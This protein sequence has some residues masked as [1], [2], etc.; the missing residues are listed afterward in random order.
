MTEIRGKRVL[1]T[2]GAGFIGTHM[3]KRLAA[4]NEVAVLDVA[5][6]GS[7]GY[8]PLARTGRIRTIQADVRDAEAVERAV[9][10]AQIVLHFASLIGVRH[11][12]SHAR[13]TMDTVLLGT[14]NVLE[15]AAR[16]RADIERVVYLSTSEVY[17][18][19]LAAGEASP[20]SM[21]CGNDPRVSYAS[22][23][24]A[25]E[26]M[27]WAYHRDFG[28]PTVIIRPFNVYGPYRTVS[29]A[30][31]I[32]AVKALSGSPITV[33]GDG[34]QL[35]SWCYVDDFCD[36]LVEALARPAA[37]G[38][39][40]NVG[41]PDASVT[42]HALAERIVEL[43]ASASCIRFLPHSFSDIGVRAPQ[44][45]HARQWL[46]FNPAHDLVSGLRRTIA[47]YREHLA[48]FHEW[49]E[50]APAARP[51]PAHEPAPLPRA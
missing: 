25:G 5:F 29:H 35:R 46:G 12:I 34:T 30:V 45:D 38:Q 15:A 40:F 4:E 22:A 13:L 20:A 10:G 43:S 16:H 36:A 33:H 17:G 9:A 39:H 47:W 14:R 3:A 24:L 18:D 1:I 21:G 51:R 31:G 49:Q 6:G 37:V 32:F 42:I 23:K 41:N 50:P 28:L 7:L 11:V 8:T 26:H 27:V 2:G 19:T 48:D 44:I